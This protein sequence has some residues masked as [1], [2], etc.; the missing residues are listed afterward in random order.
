MSSGKTLLLLRHAKSDWNDFTL[1]DRERP[2]NARG[3]RDAERMSRRWADG[4]PKPDL[5]VC[6]PAA[7]AYET[8]LAVARRIGY[9]ARD[10][11]VDE[12]LYGGSAAEVLEVVGEL[13][14]RAERVMLV[15]HNP[16]FSDVA[17]RFCGAPIRMPTCSRAEFEF[18][19]SDWASVC[20]TRPRRARIELPKRTA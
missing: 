17:Q 8:A 9:K 18:S 1:S 20:G 6:S 16:E 5:I 4:R 7:R 14:D 11:V 19:A 15:G 2:L 10:I 13:D 3:E 12:R